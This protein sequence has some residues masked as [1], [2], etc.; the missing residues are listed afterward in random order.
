MNWPLLW[1]QMTFRTSTQCFPTW[2][3]AST[4]TPIKIVSADDLRK[5]IAQYPSVFIFDGLDEV[6]SST[7]RELVLKSIREFWID[8]GNYNADVLS[9]ATS[10]PQGYNSEFSRANHTHRRLVP[11]HRDLGIRFAERLVEVRYGANR[12]RKDIVLGRLKRGI[13]QR[14]NISVD[15]LPSSDYDYGR[16]SR[17]DGPAA[18]NAVGSV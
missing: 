5:C 6:A 8:V 10:R 17:Q 9:I 4:N 11:L 16:L 12:E 18:R 15:A 7:S 2:P 1:R 14:I 3:T 13:R